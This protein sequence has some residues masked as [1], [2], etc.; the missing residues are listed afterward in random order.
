MHPISIFDLLGAQIEACHEIG[1]K[2]PIYHTF[3]WSC[4]DADAHPEWCV[5][6]RDGNIVTSLIG[7]KQSKR[8]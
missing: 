8:F 7:Q 4:N 2:C 1:M 5:R 3:G 6:D